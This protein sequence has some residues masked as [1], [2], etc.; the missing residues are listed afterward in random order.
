MFGIN[1]WEAIILVVLAVVVLGPE[2]LPEYAAKLAH[3][4][5]KLRV[6]AEGAKVQLKDQLGEDYKDINWRQY[7]PRQYDPRRIVREA[8]QEPLDFVAEPFRDVRDEVKGITDEVKA[9]KDGVGSSL[10]TGGLA[11]AT[12]AAV[13]PPPAQVVL[14]G[15][16]VGSQGSG[17]TFW[18]S[19]AT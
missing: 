6:M 4:V 8:L 12:S 1:G 18:D 16:S 15:V 17:R 2:Q 11:A 10:T 19:E 14:S 3:G 9:I 5:R 13:G 7:D